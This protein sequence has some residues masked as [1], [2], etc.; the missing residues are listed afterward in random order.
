MSGPETPEP[1]GRRIVHE[2]LIDAPLAT[3]WR[4]V[5]SRALIAEW[6]GANDLEPEAGRLFRLELPGEAGEVS[7]TDGKVLD[8]APERRL[9]FSLTERDDKESEPAEIR[10]TVQID[11]IET[12]AGVLLRLTHDGFERVTVAQIDGPHGCA[13]RASEAGMGGLTMNLVPMVVEQSSRGERSFDIF[14]RLLRERI[15]FLNGPI[16]DGV[17][18][19]VCAQL[20]FL[21]AEN[22]KKEIA[23]YIN[24]PGGVVTAGFAIY[25]TMQYIKSPVSTLC[26]GMAASMGS[27]LLM[28]GEPGHRV[29]LPNTS[30]I[31]HQPSGGYS[32]QASDM[33]RH[34]EDII[35]TKRRLT[36]L[37]AKHCGRTYEEV[38]R[39]LDRDNFLDAEQAKA[40]GLVD[41]VYE[42][43]EEGEAA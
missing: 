29:C 12:E 31:L 5:T 35:K 1:E 40:W 7:I 21:E 2:A 23:L 17:S 33:A 37:Y 6:L 4:A 26:S 39:A 10:S 42:R 25:D 41:H 38:E 16:D 15:I 3:V 20:L 36:E 24:S 18:A 30:V 34:A 43:R 27:F 13:L 9:R 14:S 22:P 32:G 28:A 11:L 19:L 8:V